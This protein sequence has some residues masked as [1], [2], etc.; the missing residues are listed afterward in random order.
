MRALGL[1]ILAVVCSGVSAFFEGF[2]PYVSPLDYT[3]SS[4]KLLRRQGCPGGFTNC[5]AL[6]N[7]GACCPTDQVCARDL[8]GNV[9][10]CPV[11]AS[12]TGTIGGAATGASTGSSTGPGLVGDRQRHPQYRRLRQ[13]QAD[14]FSQARPRLQRHQSLDRLLQAFPSH[15]CLY[16]QR[17]PMLPNARLTPHHAQTNISLA[18]QH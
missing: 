13:P 16:Q 8:A 3:E 9:A 11:R 5:G 10:C 15:S 4:R 17:S 7:S 1:S 14:L 2:A 6:G 18:L 12:C